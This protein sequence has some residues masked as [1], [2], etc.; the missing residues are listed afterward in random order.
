[1]THQAVERR[2]GVIITGQLASGQLYTDAFVSRHHARVRAAFNAVTQPT[3]VRSIVAALK[4]Q[5]DLTLAEVRRLITAKIL[6]GSLTGIEARALYT[7]EVFLLSQQN[8]VDQFVSSNQY[9]EFDM[10][11]RWH[12]TQPTAYLQARYP[13]GAMLLLSSCGLSR[14]CLDTVASSLEECATSNCLLDVWM[15]ILYEP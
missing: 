6:I 12:I 5:E 14:D 8:A 1:M 4:L 3:L 9:I 15:L 10:L 2:L 11:K 13:D 7:P